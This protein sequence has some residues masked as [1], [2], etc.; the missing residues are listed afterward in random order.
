MARQC[1]LLGSDQRLAGGKGRAGSGP[2]DGGPR[3]RENKPTPRCV[4]EEEHGNTGARERR[5]TGTQEVR[6]VEA[7]AGRGRPPE[8]CLGPV[9]VADADTLSTSS[10]GCGGTTGD[11]YSLT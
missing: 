6:P 2:A 3:R 9:S 1:R 5:D 7:A 8:S 10:S 11:G 4:E